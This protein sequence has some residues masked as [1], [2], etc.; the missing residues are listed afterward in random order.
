M[1]PCAV[2]FSKTG[3]RI[4]GK[5]LHCKETHDGE[6]G[7]CVKGDLLEIGVRVG[8]MFHPLESMSLEELINELMKDFPD[9]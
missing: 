5:C 6:F 3:T 2:S 8:V 4:I 1:E 7:F 9:E